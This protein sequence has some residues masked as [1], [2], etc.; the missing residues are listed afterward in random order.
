MIE[1]ENLGGNLPIKCLMLVMN[2]KTLMNF[3]PTN[4][5]HRTIV[6]FNYIKN[7]LY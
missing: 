2:R 4:N 1:V 5:L 3:Q 6:D 7:I